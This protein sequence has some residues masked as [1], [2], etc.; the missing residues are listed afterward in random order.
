LAG[1]IFDLD[2]TLVDSALAI[3][4][5]ANALMDE[6]GLVHLDEAETRAYIGHGAENFVEQAL[7]ARGALDT[8]TFKA[9]AAHFL[10]LL[11][12]APGKANR[13]FA[14]VDEVLR[15]LYREGHRLGTCTNKPAA[16]TKVILRAHGWDGLF[17]VVIAGDSLPVCK[18]N[19]EP[20][21]EAARMLGSMPVVFVG[22]S[23]VDA[24]TATRAGIAFILFSE[25]YRK[26]PIEQIV[27]AAAF[28]DFTL[29][30]AL[31]RQHAI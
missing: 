21:K 20:L 11:S 12:A 10:S 6:L 2:G 16:P 31:I 27:A 26:T 7:A 17:S 5:V 22:D 24:E 4:D 28:S 30:P 18:P 1:I 15:L 23:E 19:P 3:R 9:H 25:G 29:L 13:P 14:G 8:K